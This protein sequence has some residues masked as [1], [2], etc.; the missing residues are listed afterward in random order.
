MLEKEKLKKVKIIHL[1][2]NVMS[3]KTI[4]IRYHDGRK[5]NS[6]KQRIY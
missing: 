2:K 1:V 6:I 3:N 5:H 4:I